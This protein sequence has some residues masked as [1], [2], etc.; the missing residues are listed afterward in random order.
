MKVTFRTFALLAKC[1][2]F[3]ILCHAILFTFVASNNKSLVYSALF[4]LQPFLKNL[5]SITFW[6]HEEEEDRKEK[7]ERE[8]KSKGI[9]CVNKCTLFSFDAKKFS[10]F[11]V[12]LLFLCWIQRSNFSPSTLNMLH[13]QES[14]W[15]KLQIQCWKFPLL[16]YVT[17][18]EPKK[19]YQRI[20]EIQ[21]F[22]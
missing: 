12:V 16:N 14:T 3:I 1:P 19:K 7:G 10:A 13:F 9:A 4:W 5:G 22:I 11:T 20:I 8:W 2:L 17:Y 18:A 6:K 15:S 21:S